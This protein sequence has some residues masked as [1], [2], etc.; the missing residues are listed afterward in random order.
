LDGRTALN[1]EA[2]KGKKEMLEEVWIWRGE[3]Q[4]DPSVSKLG[5]F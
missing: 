3:V 1:I 4:V 2:W 5:L